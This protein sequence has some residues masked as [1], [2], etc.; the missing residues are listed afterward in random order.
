MTDMD[1]VSPQNHP[2]LTSCIDAGSRK[3]KLIRQINRF[4]KLCHLDKVEEISETEGRGIWG[5]WVLRLRLAW[6]AAACTRRL[7][8]GASSSK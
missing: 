2:R 4:R 6:R 1:Y 3:L 7:S 5:E 8:N